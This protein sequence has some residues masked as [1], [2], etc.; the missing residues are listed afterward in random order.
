[1]EKPSPKKR[2]D[3][4]WALGII[5]FRQEIKLKKRTGGSGVR[6]HILKMQC[7]SRDKEGMFQRDQDRTGIEFR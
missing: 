5:K 2:R 7:Y 3:F 4:S 6:G 1:M